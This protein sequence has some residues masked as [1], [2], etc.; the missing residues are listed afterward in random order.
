MGIRRF[1]RLANNGL[2]RAASLPVQLLNLHSRA[3]VVEDLSERMLTE[4]ETR[5]G[6]IRFYCPSPLLTSRAE[7]LLTKEPDTIK[8]IDS[9][10]KD[11]VFWDVGANVGV[12]SLYAAARSGVSV[13]SFEP[14]AANFHVLSRNIQLNNCSD[15]VTAYCV[16]LAGVTE[17]GMLNIASPKMGSALTQFGKLGEMSPYCEKGTNGSSHGMIGFTVDDFIDQFHPAF[18]NYIKLDVDGL[19]LSILQGAKKTLQDSRLRSLVVELSLTH[20]AERDQAGS[21][22]EECGF[23][24]QSVGEGQSTSE[25]VGANHLFVRKT[26]R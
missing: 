26:D 13:L 7:T 19:E 21:Y 11:A 15:R 5:S 10:T 25:G 16:A 24:L 22:L 2:S 1:T 14:L 23:Q 6:P 3:R 18:P 9:F 12:Y 4:I 17:L 8:W 20:D